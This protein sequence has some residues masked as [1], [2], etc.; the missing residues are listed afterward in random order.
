MAH[1]NMQSIADAL[2]RQGIATLRFDFPFIE[3]GRRRVDSREVATAAIEAAVADAR[4]RSPLPLW[5]GG[6]SFGGRMATHAVL[7]RMLAVAGLILC[8]FPLHAAGRPS[9]ERAAHLSSI[10]L[11]T[12]FLS[13]TRDALA[14]PQLL[15]PLV[16]ALPR[17]ELH[18]LD[19]ADH[20]YRVLARTR[21]SRE[22]VFAEMA[23]AARGFVERHATG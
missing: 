23:R 2:A 17:A 21:G 14:E 15:G 5:L 22:D 8:S 9:T 18:W 20:G 7:D 4:G 12:L 16:A 19:T 1:R 11:P 6:H 10:D 13:G 3:A